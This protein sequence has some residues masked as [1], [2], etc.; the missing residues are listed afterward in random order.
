MGTHNNDSRNMII[1]SFIFNY[2]TMYDYMTDL[3]HKKKKTVKKLD[4]K[5]MTVTCIM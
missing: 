5:K 2:I 4:Q 1:Y 3:L